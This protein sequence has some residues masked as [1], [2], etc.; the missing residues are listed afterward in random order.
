[1]P[2]RSKSKRSSRIRT[3]ETR[4][5]EPKQKRLASPNRVT[6]KVMPKTPATIP[7]S[8]NKQDTLT[9]RGFDLS[10]SRSEDINMD[11]SDDVG[12]AY[13]ENI[14]RKRQK[15]MTQ[16]LTQVGFV[17]RQEPDD[18]DLNYIT[19]PKIS[20]GKDPRSRNRKKPLP[21]Q[22]ITRQTR[23]TRKRAA[24]TSVQNTE[25]EGEEEEQQ[26]KAEI[27]NDRTSRQ[28]ILEGS[29]LPP[30]T[31]PLSRRREIPCSQSSADTPISSRS[32]WSARDISRSPLKEKSTNARRKVLSPGGAVTRLLIK[33][34]AD[35][36]DHN[37]KND[38]LPSGEQLTRLTSSMKS[39]ESTLSTSLSQETHIADGNE[40]SAPS[41]KQIREA[42]VDDSTSY[43]PWFPKAEVSDTDDDD[44][45]ASL[46]DEGENPIKPDTQPNSSN[47]ARPPTVP[48]HSQHRKPS[49]PI[50]QTLQAKFPSSR[51]NP[52]TI[53]R[54]LSNS[55]SSPMDGPSTQ[56][57]QDLLTY[58]P[59]GPSSSLERESQSE[60]AGHGYISSSLPSSPPHRLLPPRT[61]NHNPQNQNQNNK[62]KEKKKEKEKE[63]EIEKVPNPPSRSSTLEIQ[64]KPLSLPPSQTSTV[65]ITQPPSSA[66]PSSPNS[67][68]KFLLLPPPLSSSPFPYH[69]TTVPVLNPNG[70][71][72]AAGEIQE[73]DGVR[74]TDSQLL[75]D[76]I[77]NDNFD[78][79][80]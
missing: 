73:W 52:H 42:D 72:Q 23:S 50:L 11:Y 79:W 61:T 65:D 40:E 80:E 29:M 8:K 28:Y 9:Q 30:A 13:E 21:Q 7:R 1:M 22:P 38:E 71:N 5:S 3:Y 10:S 46:V 36:M 77:M 4:S 18:L 32:Y 15:T 63:T 58:T 26:V 67:N 49:T 27:N 54:H 59:I 60:N 45:E 34:V 25:P 47:L 44:E 69:P 20:Y 14:P 64:S 70:C 62:D 17:T 39:E 43:T 51:S 56:L 19:E 78:V 35:S 76:S 33:E 57:T 24:E 12:E 55:S 37:K 68:S 48:P 66:S 6:K 16:T 74:L 75:P 53:I 41:Q 2:P 31:P